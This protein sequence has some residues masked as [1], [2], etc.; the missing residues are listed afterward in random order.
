MR[1]EAC[2]IDQKPPAADAV[3]GIGLQIAGQVVLVIFTA[4]VNAAYIAL[5]YM[6]VACR[7]ARYAIRMLRPASCCLLLLLASSI[8]IAARSAR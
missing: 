8:L 1:P 2:E 4:V 3:C 6:G 5:C 7:C